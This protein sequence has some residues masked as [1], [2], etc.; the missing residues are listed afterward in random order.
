[1][2]PSMQIAFVA[3]STQYGGA[4]KYLNEL[5][6]TLVDHGH[7]VVLFGSIP[8]WKFDQKSTGVDGKWSRKSSFENMRKFRQDKRRILNSIKDEIGN[9]SIDLF[10]LQFK[11]EQISLTAR[12][13]EIAPVVWT[14][15]GMLPGPV[16]SGPLKVPYL[17]ASRFAFEIIAVSSQ[18]AT[19]LQY[20]LHRNCKVITNGVDL[21]F[22]KLPSAQTRF[23]ARIGFDLEESRLT[24][25]VVSRLHKDKGIDI[26]IRTMDYLQGPATLLIAGDGP[27]RNKLERLAERRNVRFMG[28]ISDLRQLYDAADVFLFLSS[29]KAREGFPLGILEATAHGIPVIASK[30]SGVSEELL[31]GIG[32]VVARDPKLIAENVEVLRLQDLTTVARQW[33]DAHGMHAW[34]IAHIE[35]FAAVKSSR[36]C[37]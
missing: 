13:S 28:H 26:A 32:V 33:A 34:A 22:H 31:A 16:R 14:E 20:A 36:N 29:L 2:S 8:G 6:A 18:V 30:G 21:E 7:Q 4:E 17:K 5:A 27:Q 19:Q 24:L 35:V 37:K 23:E 9:R 3:H 12:L 15:H 25:L 11:R 1:M 10:H